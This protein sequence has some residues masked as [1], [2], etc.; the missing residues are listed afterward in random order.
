MI[1]IDFTSKQY[2]TGTKQNQVLTCSLLQYLWLSLA[3]LLNLE[4]QWRH[5]GKVVC[6]ISFTPL[7][8]THQCARS[9]WLG[10]SCYTGLSTENWTAQLSYADSVK[11]QRLES[12][13]FLSQCSSCVA[14]LNLL[15]RAESLRITGH[16]L[17]KLGC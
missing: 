2:N 6:S 7:P 17:S 3:F 5:Q 1:Y 8:I 12:S 4:N 9:L 13:T 16:P 15:W 11:W 10:S 14:T